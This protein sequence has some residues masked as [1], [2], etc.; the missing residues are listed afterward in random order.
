MDD[1]VGL[2]LDSTQTGR[3]RVCWGAEPVIPRFDVVRAETIPV[4]RHAQRLAPDRG[5][6]PAQSVLKVQITLEA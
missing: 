4:C 3:L 5:R 1:D 2:P 6:H